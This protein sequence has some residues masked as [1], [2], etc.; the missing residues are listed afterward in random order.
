MPDSSLP[1]YRRV[2]L[3]VPAL[4]DE[5]DPADWDWKMLVESDWPIHC[6]G[7]SEPVAD[8]DPDLDAVRESV[9]D[10]AFE[11][12]GVAPEDL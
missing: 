9:P 5:R 4:P 8:D 7:P 1:P 10:L 12:P 2:T 3:L 6:P 11:L